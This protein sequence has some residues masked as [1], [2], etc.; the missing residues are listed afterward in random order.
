MGRTLKRV[1]LDF[2]YPIGKQIW[3]GYDPSCSKDKISYWK[4]FKGDSICSE[5]DSVY[6]TCSESAPYCI[7]H[8]DNKKIWYYE[9]PL[10][11]G[12][13]L[14][15]T[16]TEGSPISPVFKTLEELCEWCSKNCTAFGD[17]MLSKEE[18]MKDLEGLAPLKNYIFTV[19]V[20]PITGITQVAVTDKD[21][22]TIEVFIDEVI[23]TMNYYGYEQLPNQRGIF[24]TQNPENIAREDVISILSSSALLK[25]DKDFNKYKDSY[26]W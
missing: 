8:P 21:D 11:V 10:G 26:E 5:C 6:G 15:E 1:P 18:W 20:N 9:P 12:F 14:W 3:K 22:W 23:N 4:K 16:T 24:I 7:Y 19:K 25:Y 2:D 13:Q 17:K